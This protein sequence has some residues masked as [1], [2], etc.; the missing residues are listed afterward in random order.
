MGGDEEGGKTALVVRLCAKMELLPVG[1]PPSA[2]D[3][4]CLHACFVVAPAKVQLQDGRDSK[5]GGGHIALESQSSYKARGAST[6][7]GITF[8]T[9]NHNRRSPESTRPS[10]TSLPHPLPREQTTRPSMTSLPH[11]LPREQ[12]ANRIFSFGCRIESE[13]FRS[14]LGLVYCQITAFCRINLFSFGSLASVIASLAGFR[15]LGFVEA[16]G[17]SKHG[18]W[19]CYTVG[20]HCAR[21]KPR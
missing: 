5:T 9:R 19:M 14:V 4:A 10:M 18:A 2:H 21:P 15:V 8:G 7:P 13:I 1:E 16:S 12:K 17:E 3:R 6:R 20:V 11:P